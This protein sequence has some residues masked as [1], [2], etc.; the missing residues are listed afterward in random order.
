[1]QILLIYLCLSFSNPNMNLKIINIPT[2]DKTFTYPLNILDT[3]PL[4]MKIKMNINSNINNLMYP[5]FKLNHLLN[6][7][8]KVY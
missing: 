8:V 4:R 2:K 1:M 5:F 6:D 3:K 7:F